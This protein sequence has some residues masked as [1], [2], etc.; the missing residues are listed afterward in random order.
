MTQ[1]SDTLSAKKRGSAVP[2]A[3]WTTTY[4]QRPGKLGERFTL[5]F[6]PICGAYI[7]IAP[8]SEKLASVAISKAKVVVGRTN[9]VGW[10]V[11]RTMA[12]L[13]AP[14]DVPKAAVRR[15]PPP[16]VWFLLQGNHPVKFERSQ[17][18]QP[19]LIHGLP[20]ETYRV[21]WTYDYSQFIAFFN[22]VEI[23]AQAAFDSWQANTI[24]IEPFGKPASLRDLDLLTPQEVEA[25]SRLLLVG[26]RQGYHGG[27]YFEDATT[28]AI[29]DVTPQALKA[30]YLCEWLEWYS[31]HLREDRNWVSL[32][33]AQ[34]VTATAEQ[35]GRVDEFDAEARAYMV[36]TIT[37]N[38]GG[39]GERD[40]RG[41]WDYR[42]YANECAKACARLD[43]EMQRVIRE[44]YIESLK[45]Y[46]RT[47]KWLEA[48]E[49][50]RK[51]L[52]AEHPHFSGLFT[53]DQDLTLQEPAAWNPFIAYFDFYLAG[54]TF[55][56]EGLTAN[57]R[58]SEEQ[59]TAAFGWIENHRRKLLQRD[60][61][62]DRLTWHLSR[63][64]P[65]EQAKRL[66]DLYNRYTRQCAALGHA[67]W[68]E[69]DQGYLATA[70]QWRAFAQKAGW[71]GNLGNGA[72]ALLQG[73]VGS[74]ALTHK[75]NL[76][77]ARAAIRLMVRL[78]QWSLHGVLHAAQ[79]GGTQ[80][81]YS[82]TARENVVSVG[83][84]IFD[85]GAG[86]ASRVHLAGGEYRVLTR[87]DVQ[88]IR[89]VN[90]ATSPITG[91][92]Q[93]QPAK[94]H[95]LEVSFGKRIVEI[96]ADPRTIE[97][98]T[99]RSESLGNFANLLNA[100]VAVYNLANN[101]EGFD[102]FSARAVQTGTWSALQGVGSAAHVAEI[103]LA[104]K[105]ATPALRELLPW[106]RNAGTFGL[107]AEGL[108]NL[109]DGIKVLY[110]E[111]SDAVK[112]LDQG[113]A[114]GAQLEMVKGVA[115][116]SA[117]LGGVGSV[118]VGLLGG[119]LSLAATPFALFL[120]LGTLAVVAT[121]ASIYARTGSENRVQPL[122]DRVTQANQNE[123]HLDARGRQTERVSKGPRLR[124]RIGVLNHLVNQEG[125]A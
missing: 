116:V 120:G 74:H 40:W 32:L 104:A 122:I 82:F 22:D 117:G 21:F 19:E 38:I 111:D 70:P 46:E 66:Q 95:T 97:R 14:D 72:S 102:F 48:A 54:M 24:T 106:A 57:I 118:A 69:A 107:G 7:A 108:Y 89:P 52:N 105:G 114:I 61:P 28:T 2:I 11:E 119:S 125:A 13:G 115:Q 42:R 92:E 35:A 49:T 124:Q 56:Q 20:N 26:K 94:L 121:E 59:V 5:D 76:R 64:V 84:D 67:W 79:V 60:M 4:E 73:F 110:S 29:F 6:Q 93:V 100:A 88:L 34:H 58:A 83:I 23:D 71:I 27:W 90:G 39:R 78:E 15:L 47:G 68:L 123:F 77:S 98:L 81:R 80:G 31:A 86:G 101:E 33:T 63:A 43:F 10:T 85:A 91:V 96:P 16:S 30:L 112:R 1:T 87:R 62:F 44:R 50:L 103:L 75:H 18:A 8:S 45:V 41:F 9:D 53:T 65:P 113:D 3:L 51:Q 36:R 109:Q 99:N 12:T 17:K 25:V 37:A 55:K